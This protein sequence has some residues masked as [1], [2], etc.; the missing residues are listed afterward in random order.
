MVAIEPRVPIPEEERA[1]FDCA[2]TAPRQP[3][4][5][6]GDDYRETRE[7]CDNGGCC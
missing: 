7:S 2:R 4:E 1:P 6:K 3:R 5:S